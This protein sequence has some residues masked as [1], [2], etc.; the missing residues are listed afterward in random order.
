MRYRAIDENGDMVMRNSNAYI[1]GVE[2]VRQ[3]CVTRLKLFIYEWWED[4]KD[5][6]PYWQR[7]ITNRNIG[8]AIHIIRKRIEETTNVQA[9][10]SME[11]R[12]NNETRELYLKATVQSKYGIFTIDE[13]FIQGGAS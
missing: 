3:A 11:H 13:N 4:I 2:A 8:V 1:Q 10:L 6:V 7:I 9:V 12:W 5:G